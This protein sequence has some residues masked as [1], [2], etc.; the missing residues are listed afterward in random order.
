[1]RFVR[2]AAL[3]AA[4]ALALAAPAAAAPGGTLARVSGE[5]G[6]GEAN[7]ASYNPA[8]SRDGRWV[9]FTSAASNL[10][11]GDVN[12][13]LD[14]F[15]RD[16]TT[17]ETLPVS[18][19]SAGQQ[20]NLDSY[21]P[22]ISGDGRFVVF[23]SF[24]NNLVAEDTNGHGDV[25]LH[26]RV[27]RTTTRV[28]V[29][30]DGVEGN[31]DSG[32]AVI[33][34]D[35]NTIA[36]ESGATTLHPEASASNTE[37]FVLDRPSGVL[38]FVSRAFTGGRA[39][40]GSGEIS[41]SEDGSVVAFAS[42]ATNLVL[43]DVNLSDDVFVRNRDLGLTKRVSVNSLGGEANS[44]SGNPSLSADG[45][46]VAFASLASSLTALDPTGESVPKPLFSVLNVGD[47]NFAADVFVHDLLT[48]TTKLVSVSN[49][50][51]QGSG[52]SSE[53]SLSGDGRLVAF[54]SS[55]PNLVPGDR[56]DLPEIFLHDLMTGQ[57]T[58][59]SAGSA[60]R[61]G[62]G[63]SAQPEISADGTRVAFT[64]EASNLVPDDR[65]RD[66]DVFVLS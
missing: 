22:S 64:S 44:D 12:N 14:V 59:A 7:N 16:T 3:S 63:V 19:S 8:I 60:D 17:G 33:S 32:F 46:R 28:S 66:S 52:D 51:V 9:A 30:P 55:A 34:G 4:A 42:A 23:D 20:G 37:I 18:L 38:D 53:P 2:I 24:A 62:N 43:G 41:L 13:R 6:K 57:T 26:D 36:F 25:F 11:P 54:T 56:N 40:G 48:G 31:A 15:V 10:V 47:T 50:G 58:Q 49:A 39:N 35:G 5:S 65:N 21:S 27:E 1:M 45:G 61:Q 29:G